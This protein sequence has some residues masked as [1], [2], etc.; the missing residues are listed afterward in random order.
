MNILLS[1]ALKNVT[2]ILTYY[3]QSMMYFLLCV[4]VKVKKLISVDF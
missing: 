4:V 2:L 3:P 1:Q